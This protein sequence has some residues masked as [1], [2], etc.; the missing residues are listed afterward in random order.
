MNTYEYLQ[1]TPS[2]IGPMEHDLQWIFVKKS[3]N[4]I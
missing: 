3:S 1:Y 2:T 4:L